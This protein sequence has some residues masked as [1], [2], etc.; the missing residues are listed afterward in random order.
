M[1]KIKTYEIST[2]YR[3]LAE[4]VI[5][6]REELAWLENVRIQYLTSQD[7]KTHNDKSVCGECIKV[8]DIYKTFIPFDF[9]IVVYIPNVSKMTRSQRKMLMHHELLHIG[10]NNTKEGKVFK[11]VPHDIEDFRAIIEK[12]GLDWAR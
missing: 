4:E 11:V 2:E 5:S 7:N 3:E 9:L 8:E 12:Y 1:G 10:F 6:E